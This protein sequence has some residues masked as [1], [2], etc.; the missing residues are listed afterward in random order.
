ML[1]VYGHDIDVHVIIMYFLYFPLLAES[2]VDGISKTEG[3][4]YNETSKQSVYKIWS[5]NDDRRKSSEKNLKVSNSN[6]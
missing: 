5:V 2:I 6:V 3:V 1:Y 4:S